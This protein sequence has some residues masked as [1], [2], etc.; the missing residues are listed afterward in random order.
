MVPL[1]TPC[2]A[3]SASR[4]VHSDTGSAT[5]TE[6]V[7]ASPPIDLRRFDTGTGSVVVFT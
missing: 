6:C 4:R 7:S 2:A 3:D 5:L 1:A